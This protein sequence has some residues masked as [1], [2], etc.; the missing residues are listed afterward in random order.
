M[1]LRSATGGR[2]FPFAGAQNKNRSPRVRMAAFCQ[3]SGLLYLDDL[4]LQD[5]GMCSYFFL[6]KRLLGENQGES[7]DKVKAFCGLQ[8]WG[9]PLCC[10]QT[11]SDTPS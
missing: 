6:Y 2:S 5:V 4:G 8:V 3:W 1:A 7:Q 10:I 9:S 11:S